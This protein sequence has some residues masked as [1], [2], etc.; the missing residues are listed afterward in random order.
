[1]SSATGGL[2]LR[3]DLGAEYESLRSQFEQLKTKQ[4]RDAAARALTRTGQGARRAA[5]P[6]IA[7]EL[8][9]ALPRRVIERAIRFRNARGDR[10]YVDLRAVGGRKIRAALFRPKARRRGGGVTIRL[11]NRNVTL[12]DAF[13]TPA[14]NVRIRGANWRYQLY[15]ALDPRK[16]RLQRGSQPDLPIPHVYVPGVPTVFL[17]TIVVNEIRRVARERFPREFARELEV[18]SRGLVKART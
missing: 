6:L 2:N 4:V 7:K 12:P 17:E 11:G 18:R 1:M 16:K 5:A 13:L 15:S 3:I 8:S 14:G 10:L 9:D